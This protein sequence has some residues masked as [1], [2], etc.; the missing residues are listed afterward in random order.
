[1]LY[2]KYTFGS[3]VHYTYV[4]EGFT[5]WLHPRII[6]IWFSPIN[7][8]FLYNPILIFMIAGTLI[9]I[10]KRIPNGIF[11]L[12]FFLIISYLFSSWCVWYFGG[13]YGSRPFVDFYPLLSIPFGF[14]IDSLFFRKKIILQIIF[15]VLMVLLSFI[16]IKLIYNYRCFNGATWAWDDFLQTLDRSGLYNLERSSYT[17][18]NDFEN[19]TQ[20]DGILKTVTKARSGS[21]STYMMENMVYNCNY[22]WKVDNIIRHKII[23]KV[24]VSV[25]INPMFFDKTG[26]LL[27]FRIT[28]INEKL[29][30]SMIIR[31][32]DQGTRNNQWTEI[33]G[34]FEVPAGIDPADHISF[35]IWNKGEKRFY[36]DDLELEFH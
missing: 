29:I 32:D 2:W 1:M 16:N 7:G 6:E 26:A 35:Y 22:S 8:L 3:F 18:K 4:G 24:N 11:I 23:K 15:M 17:F 19:I 25:W 9:M 13:C 31:A 33:K 34:T 27:I 21:R 36:L 14:L 10:F 28:D 20:D 12:V 30:S 5:N